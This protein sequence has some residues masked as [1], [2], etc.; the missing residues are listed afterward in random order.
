[1]SFIVDLQQQADELLTQYDR[2]IITGD[3]G[4]SRL[5]ARIFHKRDGIPAPTEATVF[6]HG[7]YCEIPAGVTLAQPDIVYVNGSDGTRY[8][9]FGNY[10]HFI[11]GGFAAGADDEKAIYGEIHG[12]AT[13]EEMLVPVVVFDS[14]VRRPL[15][16]SWKFATVKIMSR[17]AKA[18]LTFNRPVSSLQVKVGSIEA[19]CSPMENKKAWNVLIKGIAAKKHSVSVYADGNLIPVDPLEILPALGGGEGDLP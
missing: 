14:N 10:D 16:A 12:G 9:V 19:E 3:H 7:R 2:V 5:A 4:T 1:M 8:A 6:S 11:R 13:P 17:R 18:Q 15:T